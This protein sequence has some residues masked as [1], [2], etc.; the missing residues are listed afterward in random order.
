[1]HALG[2]LIMSWPADHIGGYLRSGLGPALVAERDL[3]SGPGVPP[4][5]RL[6]T[7]LPSGRCGR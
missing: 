4:C 5:C 7:G 2:H 3:I 6:W 1:M